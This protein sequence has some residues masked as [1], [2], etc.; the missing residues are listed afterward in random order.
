MKTVVIIGGGPAGLRASLRAAELGARTMLVTKGAF[1]GM[2]AT[3]GPVPV[4]TLAHAARL[5][6]DAR[7]LKEYGIEVGEPILNYSRLLSRVREVVADAQAHA[8]RRKDFEPMGIA[9]RENAA[10]IR[11]LGPN[12]V[13]TSGGERFEADVFIICT[14]GASRRLSVPGADLTATHSDAW[15]LTSVP[16]SMLVVGAGATGV[17]VAS[18]FNAFG[19]KIRLFQAG[20]RIIPT[21]DASVSAEVAAQFR[22]AGIEIREDFGAI[23][24]FEKTAAGVRMHFAKDGVRGEAEASLA[25]LAVG[26]VANTGGLGLD[27]AGVKLDDRGFVAVDRYQQTSASNIFAA[28]DVTGRQM[29]VPQALQEGFVAGTNAVAPATL[30]LG[31]EV[32]PVG[33]FTDPEY[34]NVGLT[35]EQARA[36]GDVLAVTMR[37]SEISR[38]IIDGRTS[39]FCK[40]LVDRQAERLVGCH[41]VGERAVDIA[42]VAAM[43]VNGAMTLRELLRIPLAFPTYA[44]V[45]YRAASKAADA[46]KIT[47]A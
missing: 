44:G 37:F 27:A 2:A 29:L 19:T 22:D 28:G 26:W 46:L 20:P 9:L 23:E 4:R 25:V 17:Q 6:R 10:G 21:E 7:Q 13:V 15:G 1:G 24:S 30:R 34:A 32:G 47:A 3:D 43:V 8:A 35:E 16:E 18:I 41:V 38:P 40:I 39:G 5:M 42:E 45:L 31:D 33:S 14:G 12:A 11:F 36:Q